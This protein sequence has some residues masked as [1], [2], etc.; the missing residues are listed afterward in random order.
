MATDEYDTDTTETFDYV[1]DYEDEEC[2]QTSLIQ[3]GA[4]LTPFFFA[5]VII[6]S[7]FGN[8]LVLV[9]LVK[10]EN[11]KCITNTFILNLAVSD[12]LF[13][14]GLPF[15]AHYHMF[16]WTL[17]NPL[18]LTVN[19]IFYVGFYSSGFLLILMTV[20]RYIAV[21]NPLSDIVSASGLSSIIATVIIWVVSI[22]AGSPVLFFVKVKPPDYC[23]FDSSEG[24]KWG[25]YQQNA[26]FI[27]TSV[28]FISC[29]SQILCRLLHPPAQRRRN[30]TVK[31]IFT[32]MIVFFVGWGPYNVVIF[33]KTLSIS[34]ICQ[35]S[36]DL[37]YAFYIS[38]LLAFSHCCLNPVF[39]VFMGVKFKTHLKKILRNCG[40]NNS[41]NIP[42]RRSRLTIT[43]QLSGE[44]FSM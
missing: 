15:W 32:L 16:G 28:V 33:L 43:S 1:T 21:I 36:I 29:Y 11:L 9:I 37:N 18:C 25:T 17:G 13:T 10:Y 8:I 38:R 40:Q 30:K 23:G 41:S 20:H 5:I 39:Y 19:F 6:L 31:L 27:L 14:A 42:N 35:T 7:L 44:E 4:K 34:E 26:L 12:L 22:L 3:F 24:N 2:N